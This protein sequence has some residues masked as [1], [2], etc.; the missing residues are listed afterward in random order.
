MNV[1]LSDTQSKASTLLWDPAQ[2]GAEE[3]RLGDFVRFVEAR[4]AGP[5]GGYDHAAFLKLHAW[6]VSEPEKFWDAVWDFS[7]VIGDKGTK[8]IEKIKDVPWARFFPDSKISY[9]ENLLY[10]VHKKPD[11][12][13]IIA[14]TQN[15]PDRVLT[16]E[17]LCHEVSIWQ[18]AL[19]AA[20]VVEGDRV[21]VYLPNVPETVVIL[22]AASNIGAVFASAG[23]EMGQADL[24][25][26]FKQ[27]RPK[28]LITA[29]GYTH[30]DKTISRAA[31]IE[32][33]RKEIESLEK[34]V[35]LK[36]GVCELTAGIE[37]Q[38]LKFVRRD[39]NH[40]LYILF[41]SGSTGKPKCFEHSTGGVMLKH[42]SE[43]LLH[44]DVRPGDRVF[45]HATP[46]WMMWN[47]L[48]GALSVG[49][50]V[51][52]YDG[53][54]AYPDA[55]AQW[56]FTTSNGCT[57]HGSAAP[58][59]LSWEQAKILPRERYDLSGLRVIMSTGAVLPKQGFEFIHGA[60]KDNVKIGSI[61]G[62]TDI[63]GCFLGGNAFTPTYAGQINGPMLGCDVQVWDD[64]GKP[65]D[66]G[67]MVCANAFPSMPLRFVDDEKGERYSAEYFEFYQ[68][69]KVWRHG[70]SIEKTT[71]GQLV[72]I[73]RSDATLNQNGV[74]IG[75][76]A[77]Y[78]QLKP[79]G[80]RFKEAAVIDFTRPNNK[81]TITVLFLALPD[82]ANEVPEDLKTAIKKAVKDNITPY[83][84]PTEIIAVPGVLKTPN[85]KIAEVVMKKIVN[86]KSIPNASLY[87]EELVKN[88]EKIGVDLARKY[89][90]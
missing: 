16:W 63:V 6:S 52:M 68:G 13:A 75:T 43:Y 76:V 87:G 28:I 71:E 57:H 32:S 70:D 89:G 65:V 18:Q 9:A 29:E 78:D 40:P 53:N 23:M 69:K 74:R 34:I 67:E 8:V 44:C 46:S 31:V 21:A 90:G 79:F 10:R 33:A 25:N 3:S 56:E 64:D 27:V 7:G 19:E 62:G 83:A 24:I 15:G 54:P 50:T 85:G 41:S 58:L 22:L 86:G 84:I 61:S 51:L 59:I 39:F 38:P 60:V 48:A 47:W 81:Q 80:N 1:A 17:D 72:I 14:R 5:F 37:P 82:G 88:F 11:D 26:R 20:G 55:Y 35:L 45:Y 12:P 2:N 66:A 42:F 30:G 73:G 49:A 77:I 36:D 4:G